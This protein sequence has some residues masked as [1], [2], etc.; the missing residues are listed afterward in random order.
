MSEKT[1]PNLN[2]FPALA[3]TCQNFKEKDLIIGR[4][5]DLTQRTRCLRKLRRKCEC[6]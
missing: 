1:S 4:N 3:P 5:G 2:F 6:W